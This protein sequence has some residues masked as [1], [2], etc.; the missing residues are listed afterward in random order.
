VTA[1]HAA[2]RSRPSR[3]LLIVAAFTATTGAFWSLWTGLGVIR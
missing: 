3:N 2:V 1:R